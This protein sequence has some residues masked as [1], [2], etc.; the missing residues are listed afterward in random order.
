M[1]VTLPEII[2][3]RRVTSATRLDRLAISLC[4]IPEFS[5]I[6]DLSIYAT[7]SYGRLEAHNGSDI[8]LFLVT[9]KRKEDIGNKKEKES[10][11]VNK[12]KLGLNN[13]EFHYSEEYLKVMYL[14][15]ILSNLEGRLDDYGNFFTSRMLLLLESKPLFG[16]SNYSAIINRTVKSYYRDYHNH[17][18]DFKPIFLVNDIIRFWKTL[19]LNYEHKRNRVAD[20][21]KDKRKQDIKNLKLKFSRMMTCYA[22][23]VAI[24]AQ[25]NVIRPVEVIELV[26]ALPLDRMQGIPDINSGSSGLLRSIYDDYAWFLEITDKTEDELIEWITRKDNRD[27]AFSRARKFGGHMFSLLDDVCDSETLRYLVI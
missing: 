8:D 15:D 18:T 19:C 7:G 13:N 20:N 9:R 27:G 16:G 4:D 11:I 14:P 21:E 1:H 17:V 26:K 25:R 6:P 23:I 3:N 2:Q 12:L 24:S 10:I 5:S 22:T